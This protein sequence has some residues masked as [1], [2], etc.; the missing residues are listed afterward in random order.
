[1][2]NLRTR[3]QL[4]QDLWDWSIEEQKDALNDGAF[5]ASYDVTQD[6]VEELYNSLS[7]G[8]T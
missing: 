8:L 6:Q 2:K 3:I 7:E 5:L 4:I 1:M